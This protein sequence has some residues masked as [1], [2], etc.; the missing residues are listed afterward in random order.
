LRLTLLILFFGISTYCLGQCVDNQSYVLSPEGP[1]EAGDVVEVNYTLGEFIQLNINWVIAF[2]IN[3]GEGWTDLTP[4]SE[5]DNPNPYNVHG[6][7]NWFW[8]DS[9]TFPSGLNFG[10]GWRFNNTGWIQYRY[11]PFIGFYQ[12][13]PDWGSSSTGPFT[14][15]FQLT[16]AETCTAD[17]LSISINVYGDCLTGGWNNGDC[18]EDPYFSIYDD[19]VSVAPDPDAGENY[20][21]NI[22]DYDEGLNFYELIGS[23]DDNG[24]WTPSLENGYLGYFEPSSNTAG[25]YTYTVEGECNTSQSQV[26]V[27]V[28]DVDPPNIISN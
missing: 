15:S 6:S 12:G 24:I 1:Y 17:D 13:D 3:L 14:M 4:I 23:P 22:C 18:C 27:S 20:T 2:Q 8:D 16:V 21:L 7:G 26:N 19:F 25:V 28:I 10:P 5:P 9:H 11:S